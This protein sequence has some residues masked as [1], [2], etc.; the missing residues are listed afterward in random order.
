MFW[1]RRYR[2]VT[3]TLCAL[4]AI[5][6]A[7]V[8]PSPTALDGPLLDLLIKALEIVIPAEDRS[9]RSS[10]VVVTLDKRSLE[11]PDLAPYPRTLLAPAWA[12]ALDAV[13]EAG[14]L[15]VGFDFLFSYSANQFLPNYDL[16]FLAALG[17]R[18][19]K[20]VLARSAA[21]RPA[22]QFL[23][24]LRNDEKSLGLGELVSDPDGS[25]R[26]VQAARYDVR[27]GQ[28]LPSLAG[29]LLLRAK[30][31]SMPGE[32]VLA[33]RHHLEKIPTYA[34]IDVLSCAKAAPEV[35]KQV[36]RNR[37]VLIGSTLPEE[38]RK[39]SSG[40]F[41]TPQRYDGPVLHPCGLKRL[42]A[43]V[44]DSQT[45][46]G[47]FIHAAAVEAVVSG[48]ITAT[49]P[50]AIVAGLSAATA[51]AGAAVGMFLTP[52]LAVAAILVV[53]LLIFV[54][55]TSFL[56]TDIWI[57]LALPF[58]VLAAAPVV[59]YVVRYLI[60]ERTRQRIQHAFSH[61][62]SPAIVDRL[63]S[64][65]SALKLG[66]E[67]REVTVMFADLSGFTALSGKVEPEVLTRMV[68]QYLGYIVETVEASGG[69]I[70]KFIGDAVMAI[71]GAPVADPQHPVNGIRAAMAAVARIRQ[72]KGAAE[73]RGEISFSVKIG[74]NSGPAVV[75]NVGTD[76][77]YN[78]TA[79]GETV[80]VAS[81]LEGV[82][83]LYGC[84][85]VV[86]PRTAELAKD[87]FLMREL[88][89][90]QVK[91]RETPLSI[92]EPLVERNKATSEQINRASRFAEALAHYR[93]MRFNEA[94][95]I[96]SE[97][98]PEERSSSISHDGKGHLLNPPAIMA[99][100]A[101]AFLANPPL[102]QWDGVWVLS[103]K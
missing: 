63:A 13:F 9:E 44:P 42:G 26:R 14:A 97:L 30:G 10:V 27:S 51:T 46:P 54:A 39:I 4:A 1:R 50:R 11:N 25:Y 38:D 65:A 89:W 59:A 82:P 53:A 68:N 15:A 45:V 52:W 7:I 100:R 60:E 83:A 92:F 48:H 61:Y 62:L 43:S 94:F 17:K 88:D 86:G 29:A 64:D 37:I 76:K 90:V 2:E 3:C 95:T 58:F 33:P 66:G 40:R 57:P 77:R 81:R 85:L 22:L 80:N 24:A 71:W 78:Y 23:A 67:R 87:E 8:L 56:A 96:W 35:L 75:G 102:R 99:E 84:H 101:R 70:D 69:Y 36:F 103:E 73:T 31:V 49:T 91:G 34:L 74:L 98:A 28:S 12:S 47:V 41:L 18:R 20:I 32:I 19:D 21:T 72:E 93:A 16:P 5:F 79:V 6:F 55:A